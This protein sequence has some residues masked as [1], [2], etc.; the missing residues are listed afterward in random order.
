MRRARINSTHVIRCAIYGCDFC[1]TV[2]VALFVWM[3]CT[4]G[5]STAAVMLAMIVCALISVY[6]LTFAYKRYMRLDHP[7]FTALASQVIVTLAM[8]DLVLNS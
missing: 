5:D 6:R 4:R 3:L 7:F 8:I 1:V 2:V